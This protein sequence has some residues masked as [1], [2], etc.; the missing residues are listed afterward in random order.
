MSHTP[1]PWHV[2]DRE[3]W[4]D[5]HERILTTTFSAFDRAT[6][7][8]NVERICACVNALAGVPTELLT[9]ET[10]PTL[11]VLGLAA[12]GGD[13]AAGRA[14]CDELMSQMEDVPITVGDV[15]MHP[16]RIP[17]D[18]RFSFAYVREVNPLTIGVVYQPDYSH[19]WQIP[20]A[21]VRRVGR[22]PW[23]KEG[24]TA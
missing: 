4:D 10:K 6:D 18:H 13:I 7:D 5:R 20:I 21:N 3:I 1:E 15:V 2:D 17:E 8:Q 23:A 16:A 19:I 22:N 14:L 9:A 24:V 12:M 11:F